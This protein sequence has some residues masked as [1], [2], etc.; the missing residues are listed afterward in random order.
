M[1][2]VP[3]ELYDDDHNDTIGVSSRELEYMYYVML[4]TTRLIPPIMISIYIYYLF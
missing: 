2:Q 3:V 1:G 4:Y